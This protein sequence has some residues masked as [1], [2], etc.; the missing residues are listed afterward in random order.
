MVWIRNRTF[1]IVLF[2][3]PD[4]RLVWTKRPAGDR[5][6]HYLRECAA[7]GSALVR[8]A[9]IP[10]GMCSCNS[11]APPHFFPIA[12]PSFKQRVM[13]LSSVW[14]KY[15]QE[16]KSSMRTL[17]VLV[18][19]YYVVVMDQM[20]V[21]SPRFITLTSN[22]QCDGIY[23]WGLWGLIRFRWRHESDAFMMGLV[24]L[25]E[26]E[27]P[28]LACLFFLQMKTQWEVAVCKPVGEPSPVSDLGLGLPSLW[29]CE[30]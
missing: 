30:K 7:L 6:A 8:H 22:L 1:S 10:M 27:R 3:L 13:P 14:C 17:N 23:R 26:E 21:S 25:Q 2:L 11:P 4:Y 16:T 5:S 18:F 12:K 24:S 19:H 20:F 9:S 15:K 29:N 28:E